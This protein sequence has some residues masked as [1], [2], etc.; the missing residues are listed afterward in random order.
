MYTRE[1]LAAELNEVKNF[2]DLTKEQAKAVKDAGLVVVF[3]AT[4]IL[5]E[6][7]G[8]INDEAGVQGGNTLLIC[9]DGI[10]CPWRNTRNYEEHEAEHYFK[11]KARSLPIKV[12]W[13]TTVDGEETSW[14]YVTEI[15]HST[16]RIMEDGELFCIGIVFSVNDLPE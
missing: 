4:G 9:R 7:L 11:N 2:Y 8:A 10:M 15:P 3:G 13:D 16:F 5:M 1:T 14:A 6:F 12:L